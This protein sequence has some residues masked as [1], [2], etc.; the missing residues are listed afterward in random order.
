MFFQFQVFIYSLIFLGVLEFLSSDSVGSGLAFLSVN[1]QWLAILIFLA[2]LFYFY[3]VAKKIS[4]RISMVAMPV[5][6]AASSMGMLYFVQSEKQETLL[7]TLA[8]I[9]YYFIHLSLYR[10]KSCKNDRTAF[11][12]IAAGCLA[13][14]FIF[15]SVA[16]GIY[17]NFAIELW[18]LMVALALITSIISFQ[19]FWM[20]NE[21]KKNVLNYSLI[22]GL[23]MAE[24]VWMLNFW[25]FGYLTTGVINLIF[26]YVL[27]DMVHCHFRD[28]LSKKRVI[29]NMIFFGFLVAMVLTSTRWMPVV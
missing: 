8:T 6:F 19:Y 21:N 18:I 15:Y 16:Y 25:P 10:L 13:A 3:Q 26:Y 28:E 29:G 7:I 9:A 27:W 23:V 22:L 20:I 12:I 24:I 2:V 4:R 11:G 14:I 1:Q 5:V 17:L